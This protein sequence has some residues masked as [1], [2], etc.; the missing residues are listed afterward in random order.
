VKGFEIAPVKIS[1]LRMPH[2]RFD[3]KAHV[4]SK[5][6]DCHDVARAKRISD[7]ALPKIDKC[8]ECHAGAKP[9]EA[10]LTSNCLLCHGFHDESHPWDPA[11]VP[12]AKNAR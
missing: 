9:V 2:A 4:S 5:C 11:F 3:H 7:V 10:K 1:P 6:V 8:R 12:R